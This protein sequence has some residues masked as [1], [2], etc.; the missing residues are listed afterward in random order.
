MG[1]EIGGRGREGGTRG[2]EGGHRGEEATVGEKPYE[3]EIR[4]DPT[5]WRRGD[6]ATVGEKLGEEPTRTLDPRPWTELGEEPTVQGPGSRVLGAGLGLTARIATGCVEG[7][8]IATGCV[9]G[10][11]M[12]TGG[13]LEAAFEAGGSQGS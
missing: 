11:G 10:P 12:A 7:P 3:G 6:E 4:R 9:E 5:R 8:G 13:R 2:E 1:L